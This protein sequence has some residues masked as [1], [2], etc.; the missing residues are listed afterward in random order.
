[1][2]YIEERFSLFEQYPEYNTAIDTKIISVHPNYG[3]IGIG[4]E[5][6]VKSLECAREMNVQ[7][8]HVLCSSHFS[9]RLCEKLSFETLYE[10]PYVDYV[11]NGENPLLPAQPHTA[12]RILVQKL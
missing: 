7:L 9:Y 10:L 3:G 11:I 8:F 12:A 2:E 5:L 1:M 6:M 4:K